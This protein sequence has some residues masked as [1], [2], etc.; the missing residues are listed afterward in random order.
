[1][2]SSKLDPKEW[3]ERQCKSLNNEPGTLNEYDGYDCEICKNKG[4]VMFL[5]ESSGT[6]NEVSREC[7]CMK[8]RKS[9]R[10]MK[11]SGLEGSISRCTFEKYE[12]VEDWQKNIKEKA[13]AFVEKVE[14]PVENSVNDKWF[15][16]GG[17]VG[18][19]KTH[20]CT[21]I[22]REFLKQGKEAVYM[23]W[24]D[25]STKLKSVINDAERYS[26]IIEPLKR[27]EVL[28]IDDFLKIVKGQNGD[29]LKPTAADLKLA[30]EIL[31]YRYQQS[32]LITIISS[33]RYVSEIEEIDS[34]IGSRIYERTKNNVCNVKR[35]KKRNYRV[36]DMK[37]I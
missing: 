13:L 4:F 23:L 3:A 34:A 14:N 18:C 6:Y 8:I 27:A 29:E 33:E 16:I 11:K 26:E 17:A 28:Y 35:D 22:V 12:A 30:Y 7:K 21:A 10:R 32:D 2:N 37:M 24:V 5:D 9:I 25:E 19:G 15:F 20:I 1:M 31:N 36:K